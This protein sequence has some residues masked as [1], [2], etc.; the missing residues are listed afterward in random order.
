MRQRLCPSRFKGTA[1]RA[2]LPWSPATRKSPPIVLHVYQ[3]SLVFDKCLMYISDDMWLQNHHGGC[4]ACFACRN[5][6]TGVDII[7]EGSGSGPIVSAV[8]SNDRIEVRLGIRLQQ[9]AVVCSAGYLAAHG[10]ATCTAWAQ[11]ANRAVTPRD[12][13]LAGS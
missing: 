8:G 2:L 7:G 1:S 10:P 6:P 9:Y 5:D 3:R 13:L 11:P 12:R 4:M